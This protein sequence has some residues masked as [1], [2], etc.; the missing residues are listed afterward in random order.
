MDFRMAVV[1]LGLSFSS[2]IISFPQLAQSQGWDHGHNP[3]PL[4]LACGGVFIGV[5]LWMIIGGGS[6]VFWIA[7]V[8]GALFVGGPIVMMLFRQLSGWVSG[9]VA[10]LLA[11][12][13]FFA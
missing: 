4:G 1:L 13:S 3:A 10:P 11:I 9:I 5:L 8:V 7:G 2:A 6:S 12:L